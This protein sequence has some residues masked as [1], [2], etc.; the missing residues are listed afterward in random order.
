MSFANPQALWLL[1]L[2]VIPLLLSRR[3]AT[4]QREVSN[5]YLWRASADANALS[6]KVRSLRR[7]WVVAVQMAA[8]A[9]MV[10][11]LAR[12]TIAAGAD[13]VAFVVDVSAS[14]SARDGVTTR[15]DV[16]RDRARSML[17][18][19]SGRARV[20]LI[21]AGASAVDLGEYNASDTALRRALD[22]LTPTAGVA[23]VPAA[24]LLETHA[25]AG[26][27]TI[28]FSDH[29]AQLVQSNAAA[30]DAAAGIPVSWEI[31]GHSSDNLALSTLVVRRRPFAPTD[32]DV[33]V[34]VRNYASRPQRADV[35]I[36]VDGRAVTRRSM[37]VETD[38]EQSVLVGVPRIGH[39]ITA[40]LV[41]DDALAVDN[42]RRE[43]AA[44]VERIRVWRAGRT[45]IYIDKAL[46]A[47]PAVVREA[48]SGGADVIV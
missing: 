40:R 22:N 6:L 20:R 4:R 31:V 1:L 19:L 9:A 7:Q 38:N 37:V 21:A 5:L 44:P 42:E 25:A 10:L 17:T 24:I 29:I 8:I 13:R 26:A 41:G 32:A 12:P 14:M 18:G 16:A 46:A 11:A 34:A 43:I 2:T 15:F 30:T 35:E 23:D 33:L 48:S 45:N 27:R 36:S 28:V 47:N 39:V 3:P